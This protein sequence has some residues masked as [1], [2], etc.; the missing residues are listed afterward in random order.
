MTARRRRILASYGQHA[1]C[2]VGILSRLAYAGVEVCKKCY[3]VR[4]PKKVKRYCE[5]IR[6]EDSNG[7]RDNS[8]SEG[9]C[10]ETRLD[11]KAK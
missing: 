5:D 7:V 9:G 3:D 1:R 10:Q 6:S 11:R 4:F 8:Y 2:F